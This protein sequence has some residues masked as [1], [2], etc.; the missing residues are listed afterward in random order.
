MKIGAGNA[1]YPDKAAL[2]VV[3]VCLVVRGVAVSA[4]WAG[5]LG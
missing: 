4:M 1:I 2:G 3:G 5:G